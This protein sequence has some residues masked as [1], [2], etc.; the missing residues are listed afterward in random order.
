MDVRIEIDGQA[1][2]WAVVK[3]EANTVKHGVR[4][5]EAATARFD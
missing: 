1:F 4:F 3:A 2:V 5:E